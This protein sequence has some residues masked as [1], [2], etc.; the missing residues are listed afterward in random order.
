MGDLRAAPG[1]VPAAVVERG[2]GGQVDAVVVGDD[3]HRDVVGVGGE[4]AL[5]AGNHADVV[6]GIAEAVAEHDDVGEL[7]RLR[8]VGREAEDDGGGEVADA[9]HD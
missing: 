3:L 9:G 1:E 4:A 8:G 5:R 2:R 6:A 7:L